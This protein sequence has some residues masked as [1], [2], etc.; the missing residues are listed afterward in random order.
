VTNVFPIHIKLT[1]GTHAE[2]AR[3]TAFLETNTA[4]NVAG[5]PKL[6]SAG[7]SAAEKAAVLTDI[8]GVVAGEAPGKPADKP[9]ATP[10]TATTDAASTAKSEPASSTT[11]PADAPA[12][13][14]YA[15]LQK[16]VNAAVPKHGKDKLLAIATKHGAKTFKDLQAAQWQA[17]YDDVV[18]LG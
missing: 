15:T 9:A 2:L 6:P 1:V 10:R 4:A 16:A 14:E 3:L 5:A 17:A 18:A 13:F 12:A 7:V 11:P 8:H